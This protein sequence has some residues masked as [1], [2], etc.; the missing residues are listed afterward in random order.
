M[1]FNIDNN[2][3]LTGRVES[4]DMSKGLFKNK[5]GSRKLRF[6]LAVQDNYNTK[7]GQPSK[8]D[9]P[10]EAFIPASM[11]KTDENGV[12]SYGIYSTVR[13]GD[14]ISIAGHI[15]DNNY[16]DADGKM[17][18]GGILVRIDSL[19]HRESKSVSEARAQQKV[20]AAATA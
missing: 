17:V 10:V 2:L 4:Q 5:D 14:L 16:A 7:D 8:Q 19:K 15:M 3:N 9:I 6:T 11:V 12:E 1:A 18:Y 13:T 20:A